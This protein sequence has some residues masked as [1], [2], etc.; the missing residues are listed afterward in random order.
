MRIV[1]AVSDAIVATAE[2]GQVQVRAGTHWPDTDPV[3]LIQPTL[4]SSDPHYGL[5]HSVQLEE[6]V[7]E[8]ATANPGEKRPDPR[9]L[10]RG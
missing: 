6:P 9:T 2:G 7:I 10:R 4:F 1:Y 5:N 8:R 3:V